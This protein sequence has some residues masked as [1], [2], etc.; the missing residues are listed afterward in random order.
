MNTIQ[1]KP[2]LDDAMAA[3]EVIAANAGYKVKAITAS[4]EEYPILKAY[5]FGRKAEFIAIDTG[6]EVH[7]MNVTGNN[8]TYTVDQFIRVY[9]AL[10]PQISYVLSKAAHKE[11][12]ICLVKSRNHV[13]Q[14]CEAAFRS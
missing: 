3:I 12:T 13:R 10:N 7:L 6:H 5:A 4:T 14:I 11:L 2:E 1:N 8:K 9:S